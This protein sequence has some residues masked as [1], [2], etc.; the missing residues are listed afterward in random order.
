MH[1][2]PT[3]FPYPVDEQEPETISFT[4]D[5]IQ[6]VFDRAYQEIKINGHNF[7]SVDVRE[8]YNSEKDNI[9]YID[10]LNLTVTVEDEE[11]LND[12]L[13]FEYMMS[14]INTR[15][16]NFYFDPDL[17]IVNK[18]EKQ[19]GDKYYTRLREAQTLISQNI[20]N[21]LDTGLKVLTAAS[22]LKI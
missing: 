11:A 9:P 5:S 13:L 8:I 3:I 12:L 14:R 17:Y 6:A 1:I 2:N 18:K 4:A 19:E 7:I 10:V 15:G 21:Q 20:L 22:K 16:L